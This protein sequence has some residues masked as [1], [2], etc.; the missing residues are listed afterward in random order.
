MAKSI[1]QRIEYLL[2]SLPDTDIPIARK[3]FANHQYEEIRELTVSAITK[4]KKARGSNDISKIQKYAYITDKR[5]LDMMKLNIELDNYLALLEEILGQDD[6]VEEPD[7]MDID[8]D[9][10]SEEDIYG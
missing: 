4:I 9:M 5:M 8:P 3:Y 2:G 1:T 6:D 10:L 7:F